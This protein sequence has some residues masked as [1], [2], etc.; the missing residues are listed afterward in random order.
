MRWINALERR[1]GHLAVPGLMRI[2][3]AFNVLVFLLSQ[4]KG[5]F[6]QLLE[7]RPDRVFAGEVWRLVSFVFIPGETAGGDGLFGPSR[8]I[9]FFLYLNLLWLMGEGLEQAW[10]SFKLNLFYLI[11]V[12]GTSVAVCCFNLDGATGFYLN[13][14]L[15]LAFATLFPNFQIL[16]FFVIPVAAKWLAIATF[17][18]LGVTFLGSEMVVRVGILVAL[19]NYLLF[20]GPSWVDRW[21]EQ[22]RIAKRQQEFQ[23]AQHETD[24]DDAALH[25]CRV[26]GRTELSSPELDFRVASDGEEYCLAHLPSRRGLQE[27]PQER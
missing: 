9:W 20:F 4:A 18:L 26:C 1:F 14:S 21:R 24:E 23:L 2:I 6:V 5:S 15:F 12:I 19:A 16:L 13:T 7:L 11:G 8:I 10:G 17:V 3:V 25:H 22:G 27:T